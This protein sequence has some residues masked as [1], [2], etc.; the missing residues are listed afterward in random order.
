MSQ[1]GEI[2]GVL[3][4]GPSQYAII[5]FE[6]FTEP[7]DHDMA[8]VQAELHT[9]LT[10]REVQKM[11]G[12]TFEKLQAN[13]RVDNFLTGESRG[14]AEAASAEQTTPAPTRSATKTPATRAPVKR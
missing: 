11:V 6:G 13:A 9:D 8:D 3:Q 12:E 10:E 4:V 14:R 2:S 7:V 1:P 5:K